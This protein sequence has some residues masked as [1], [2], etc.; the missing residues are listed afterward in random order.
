MNIKW[1]ITLIMGLLLNQV[2]FAQARDQV[3]GFDCMAYTAN[4]SSQLTYAENRNYLVSAVR[5]QSR[6]LEYRLHA[7]GPVETV[8]RGYG[9]FHFTLSR[10][11]L[12]NNQYLSFISTQSPESGASSLS[13]TVLLQTH[14]GSPFAPTMGQMLTVGTF[15]CS[16]FELK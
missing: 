7:S 16:Y 8:L 10:G 14:S 13:G 9:A 1:G 6:N 5:N 3:V 11:A 4:G 15:T 2:V 12:S